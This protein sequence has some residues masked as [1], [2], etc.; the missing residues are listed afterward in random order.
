MIDYLIVGSGLAGLC[1][2][3]RLLQDNKTF[4]IFDD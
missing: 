3:E 2:T 1:F 4:L